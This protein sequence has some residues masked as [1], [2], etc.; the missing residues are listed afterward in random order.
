M[1]CLAILGDVIIEIDLISSTPLQVALHAPSTEMRPK[2]DL[3]VK[4]LLRDAQSYAVVRS[5]SYELNVNLGEGVAV[6][7]D[8]M[9]R[10]LFIMEPDRGDRIRRAPA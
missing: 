2:R 6:G 10:G 3:T 7:D 4:R 8:H 1:C 9:V 5:S